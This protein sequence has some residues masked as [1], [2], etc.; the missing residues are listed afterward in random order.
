MNAFS[1]RIV[2][3][4]VKATIGMWIALMAVIIV[5][6]GAQNI[7]AK[8]EPTIVGGQEVNPPF[9][10][11]WMAALIN[12]TAPSGNVF[13]DQFCGGTLIQTNLVVTAAHCFFDNDEESINYGTQKLEAKD[14]DVL[15]GAHDLTD[16]AENPGL[17]QRIDV[18]QLIIHEDYD[19]SAADN[20]IAL[21][22][23]ARPVHNLSAA[24]LISK[25]SLKEP[26]TTART[27]GWGNTSATGYDYPYELQ[28]VDLP[29]VSHTTCSDA[30]SN[31][32]F[33]IT[34]HML[35]AG[36]AQGGRDSCQG[37]SGGPLVVQNA[38]QNGRWELI[39][40]VSGGQGCAQP[41]FYG[42]Y[43]D[44]YAY[45]DWIKR[46]GFSFT[47]GLPAVQFLLLGN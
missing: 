3:S 29:L 7:S 4:S 15:L 40:V 47:S 24:K 21:M 12:S 14:V 42:F 34:D 26:G 20:D 33:E 27:I 10:Y 28:D 13:L 31:I 46:N 17:R 32:G 41:G 18:S 5:I 35:C 44:V 30:Y 19:F 2:S 39:G 43:A 11:T 38:S 37:D 16:G 6:A 25:P 45:L 22:K 23:L 8:S 1:D 9:Q 36:Y